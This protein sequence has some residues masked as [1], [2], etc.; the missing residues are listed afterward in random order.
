M[1]FRNGVIRIGLKSNVTQTQF[2]IK[3]AFVK[4]I[5][6]QLLIV[7]RTLKNISKNHPKNV[8]RKQK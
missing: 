8:P 6:E 1:N 3:Q 2:Y 7:R 4:P 5:L